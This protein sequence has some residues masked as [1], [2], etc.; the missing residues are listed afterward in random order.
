VIE[1]RLYVEARS[2][3]LGKNKA[4]QRKVFTKPYAFDP[5]VTPQLFNLILRPFYGLCDRTLTPVAL[6]KNK[7]LVELLLVL[8]ELVE[9]SDSKLGLLCDFMHGYAVVSFLREK[10]ACGCKYLLSM[11]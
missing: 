8:K 6:L 1:A 10:M 4:N 2:A 5:D 7:G 3:S 11:P 9:C